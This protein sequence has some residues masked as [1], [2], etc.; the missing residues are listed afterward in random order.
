M[1]KIITIIKTLLYYIK[2]RILSFINRYI[3]HRDISPHGMNTLIFIFKYMATT[4]D[5]DDFNYADTLIYKELVELYREAQ[6]EGY[7]GS[8]HEFIYI[9]GDTLLAHIGSLPDIKIEYDYVDFKKI[10]EPLD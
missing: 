1:K 10:A 6:K 5:Q 2:I 3:R 7:N 4:F 8:F 9:T